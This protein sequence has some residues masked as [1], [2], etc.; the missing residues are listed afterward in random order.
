ME[1]KNLVQKIEEAHSFIEQAKQGKVKIKPMKIPRKAKVGK[2]KRKK[3]YIGIF[4]ID[5]N[6]NIS[7]ERQKLEDAGYMLK[8]GTFHAINKDEICMWDGKYPVII[9]PTWSINPLNIKKE[10]PINETYGQKYVMARMMKAVIAQTKKKAGW[11]LWVA[12]GV[13]AIIAYNLIT[14]GS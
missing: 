9:Q 10:K 6:L 12:L 13:G 1:D 11:L 8:G 3:G 4:R 2:N 14:K 7:G 5:E